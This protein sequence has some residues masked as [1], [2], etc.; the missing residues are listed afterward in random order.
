MN[1][2]LY[3]KLGISDYKQPYTPEVRVEMGNLYN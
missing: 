1:S 3:K 2:K